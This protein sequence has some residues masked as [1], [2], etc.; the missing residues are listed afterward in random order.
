MSAIYVGLAVLLYTIVALFSFRHIRAKRHVE[1]NSIEP[2]ELYELLKTEHVNLYDVRQPL[3]FLEYPEIIPG[4]TRVAPTDIEDLA[5]K[6]PR[7]HDSVIYCTGSDHAT[8]EMVLRKALALK[9]TR[10]KLLNGGLKVWKEK[11][12]PVEPYGKSFTLDTP[13]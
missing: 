11:G 5:R 10:V 7:N 9:F 12:Y 4:A 8:S 13:L 3:D 2:E 1:I 6:L